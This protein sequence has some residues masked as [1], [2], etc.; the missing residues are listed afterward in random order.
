MLATFKRFAPILPSTFNVLP[1]LVCVPI[2]PAFKSITWSVALPRL[3]TDCNVLASLIVT[4]PTAKSTVISV[5]AAML[6][7][8][9]LVTVKL[10][11][12]VFTLIPAPPATLNTPVLV[13]IIVAV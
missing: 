4:L 7:T 6:S 13:V 5:P 9:S 10:P 3:T 11:V 2:I 8:P 12:E 1:A